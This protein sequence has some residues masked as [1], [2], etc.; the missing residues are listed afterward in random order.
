MVSSI[1][2]HQSIGQVKVCVYLYVY[3]YIL[4]IRSTLIRPGLLS[5]V[6][7]LLNRPSKGTL[8]R[9]WRTPIGCDN[10]VGDHSALVKRQPKES[11]DVDTHK[12]ISFKPT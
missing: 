10:D 2:N 7:L 6:M 5:P 11:E 12:S 3:T 9:F 1:Y 4:H 8:L